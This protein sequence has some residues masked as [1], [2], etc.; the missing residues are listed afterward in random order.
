MKKSILYFNYRTNSRFKLLSG[1]D[2]IVLNFK[3]LICGILCRKKSKNIILL[4]KVEEYLKEKISI[5]FVLKKLNE[6]DKIKFSI[7]N[8]E[9]LY[10]FNTIPNPNFNEI[11]SESE[12][13]NSI[14]N[15][16]KLW[17]IFEFYQPNVNEEYNS[18]KKI[19]EK[20]E[21]NF[22]DINILKLI[23]NIKFSLLNEN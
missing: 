4:E 1:G 20:D 11:F 9:Q 23:K 14:N 6:V 22:M 15:V 21:P 2:H 19:K 7:F 16:D 10:L 17:R 18:Y 12:N 5:E 13:S 8:N 3:E